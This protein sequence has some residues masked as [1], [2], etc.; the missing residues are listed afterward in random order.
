MAKDLSLFFRNKF[1]GLITALGLVAYIVVYFVLPSSVNE[2]LQIGLYAEVVPPAFEQVAEE[3]IVFE[4]VESE[5][6]LVEAVA[7]GQ[8]AAGVALPP[9]ILDLLA[10]GQKPQITIYSA[11]DTPEEVTDAVEVII[12]ELAYLQAGQPLAVDISVEVLG[13]DMLGQQIPI[14]DRMRPLL[15]VFLVLFE[16][17]GLAGL[18]TDEVQQGTGRALLVTPM[19]VPDLFAAKGLLG[20]GLAFGQAALFMAVVGG[21]SSQPLII[22]TALL[23]GAVLVTGFAFLIASLSRDMM[24]A[25]GWGMLILVIFII[26]AFGILFPGTVSAWA[27]VIPSYYLADTV[28]QAAA[29]GAGWSDV[30]LNLLVLLGV[31][32]AVVVAGVAALGRRFR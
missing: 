28:H 14:R 5:D 7:E 15:A 8:F 12:R 29:F 20:V 26:P 10:S 23:L 3:G 17:I 24:S 21:M 31:D 22:L 13:P 27:R 16:M 19:T 11:A 4:T 2:T 30:S 25:L 32:L 9:D 6:A 1:F 18:I